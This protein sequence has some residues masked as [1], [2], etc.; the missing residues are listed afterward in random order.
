MQ[1]FEA[2]MKKKLAQA[3]EDR[4]RQIAESILLE[5][6]SAPQM[7]KQKKQDQIN[8]A[9]AKMAAL[10]AAKAKAKDPSKID[11]EIKALQDKI[12]MFQDQIKAIQ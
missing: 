2:L 6:P 7:K 8:A 9:N 3:F 4:K 10:R 5:M 11:F 1:A 12:K